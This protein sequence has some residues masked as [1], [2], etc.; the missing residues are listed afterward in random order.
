MKKVTSADM[1]RRFSEYCDLA[2]NEP[3]VITKNGR[4]RLVLLSVDEFNY[5]RDLVAEKQKEDA[6]RQVDGELQT[7]DSSNAAKAT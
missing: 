3:V 4:E 2:L 7:E 1:A 5:L 6:M